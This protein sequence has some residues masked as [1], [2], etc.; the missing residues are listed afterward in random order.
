MTKASPDGQRAPI[1]GA[2]RGVGIAMAGAMPGCGTP[3][4][5]PGKAVRAAAITFGRID[6]VDTHAGTV[7]RNPAT[8]ESADAR[9]RT[10]ERNI[11]ELVRTGRAML[12]E[13][14]P[15]DVL[16]ASTTS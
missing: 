11:G 12:P 1:T 7:D 15:S 16:C 9:G 5:Q 14:K 3:A 6:A 8:S 2:T 13:L 10:V 4:S